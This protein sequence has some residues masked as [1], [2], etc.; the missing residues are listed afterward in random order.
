MHAQTLFDLAGR[1]SLVIGGGKV[2]S[3]IAALFQSYGATVTLIPELGLDEK[4]V[5]AL[6]AMHPQLD[7]LVNGAIR[8]GPWTLDNL[9]MDEWDRVHAVNLRGAFLLMREATRVMRAHKRG[10]RIINL[11]TIGSMHPVLHG[12]F[13]Y[14]SSRA[15]TNALTRQFAL[16][17]AADGILTNAILVGAISSDPFPEGC[18]LPPQGPGVKPERLP[19]GY[20]KP[21]DVAP[22][23]LLLASAGGR[24][25][26]G[27][28]IVVDGG[29]Q[30]A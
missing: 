13:A 14:G 5:A 17:F 19:L 11:S 8:T 27:Q 24:Y 6:F 7:I 12:N 15:G 30:I 18:T 25:I 26:N 23:A 29:F 2:P 16:D 28:A 22:V 20:G 9:T 4:S 1:S 3:A 21:E 10:G